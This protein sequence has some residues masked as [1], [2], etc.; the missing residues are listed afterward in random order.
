MSRYP[1]FSRNPI[2]VP[3]CS[4]INDIGRYYYRFL[5]KLNQNNWSSTQ[6]V[7]LCWQSV[8]IFFVNII[9]KS[10]L[11]LLPW[12]LENWA[13]SSVLLVENLTFPNPTSYSCFFLKIKVFSCYLCL[14]QVKLSRGYIC[15]A[16]LHPLTRAR[17][18]IGYCK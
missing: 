14:F 12:V 11:L 4:S 16:G 2:L 7:E 1:F 6:N 18:G 13:Q 5:N 9:I 17:N 3:G 8:R 10:T 15:P